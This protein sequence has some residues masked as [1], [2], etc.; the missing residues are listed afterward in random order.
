MK[1]PDAL[2]EFERFLKSRGPSL[3]TLSVRDGFDT[4]IEFYRNT[5][6]DDCSIDDDATCSCSNGGRT[7]GGKVLA[8]NSISLVSSFE[9]VVRMRTS[10]S[11]R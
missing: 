5:R 4:M 10:G 9:R 11:Y 1:S 2:E 3:E 7:I 8:S 6:A